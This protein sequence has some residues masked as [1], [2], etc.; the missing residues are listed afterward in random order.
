MR[1]QMLD[2][3]LEKPVIGT[4]YFQVIFPGLGDDIDRIRMPEAR[5]LVTPA[6]EAQLNERQNRMV[7]LLVKGAESTV[8]RR[9]SR[10]P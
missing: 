7:L 10:N 2:H 4:V 5:L 1:D 3:G 9:V 8:R 6:I